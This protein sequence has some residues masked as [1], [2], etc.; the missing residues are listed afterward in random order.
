M[1]SVTKQSIT[2]LPAIG[3]VVV[4]V[5]LPDPPV[6][7]K[8]A[9]PSAANNFRL[10]IYNPRN[11]SVALGSP[12]IF[13]APSGGSFTFK[14]ASSDGSLY[15][16]V[17]A[18]SYDFDVVEPST[19]SNVMTRKRYTAT[20]AANGT[21]TVS[22]VTAN[23]NSIFAVTVT[24]NT[25]DTAARKRLVALTALATEPASTFVQTS[26]C[27]L[28]D[29]ITPNRSFNTDLSAGFPKVRIRLPSYGRM[30]AL[31]VPL[32]FAEVP[33]IDNPVTFFTPMA[34][35]VRDMY[36]NASY[37]RLAI[38][39]HIL[40]NYVRMPFSPSKYNMG[41]GNSTGNPGGYWQE[42]ISLTDTL[43]DYTQYDAVYFLVPKEMPYSTMAGPA[44]TSPI[45]V[46]G[47]YI[48]NGAS[49]GGDMYLPGNGPNAARNWMAHEF[50]HAFGLYDED[51]DHA[52]ATLG[53]WSLMAN[54]W[55]RNA[56]EHNGWDRYLM[57]WL[58]ATQVACMP[59]ATLGGTGATLKLNPLVRQN[60]DIKVAMVPLSTS[61][62]L[63]M[64]SRKSEGFDV[65]AANREGVL[66]YTVDMTIGQS[67]GPYRTQRRVGSTDR[68][69]EDAALRAG[70][71]LTIDGVEVSVLS[72]SADGDTI[73]VK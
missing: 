48:V 64:E 35:G 39:F 6:P 58:G 9:T 17:T 27:Q 44:I 8:V 52:S 4:P 25:V 3:P 46:K 15:I 62:M 69:F 56:I 38:D 53:S 26:E 67:K 41:R 40:P 13:I 12:G 34:D 49:G 61:K 11:R 24:V 18:G 45:A 1:N 37:G 47:G 19:L 60:A 63:V 33:G 59:K 7:S 29:Q 72:L 70:D 2:V 50:G 28:R 10:W 36:Y 42:I 65:I 54:G 71:T 66:V 43:I 73:R 30:K 68:N 51:L 16:P 22:G 55:S 32:D 31:I 21:V 5:V 14:T 57:G 23:A 20:V